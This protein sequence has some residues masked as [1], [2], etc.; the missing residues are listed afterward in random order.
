M[1]VDSGAAVLNKISLTFGQRF[2]SRKRETLGLPQKTFQ[3]REE[4]EQRLWAEV[5]LALQSRN[6][7]SLSP[8]WLD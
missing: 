7:S 5:S 6:R 2:K 4:S 8:G 1:L 3:Q